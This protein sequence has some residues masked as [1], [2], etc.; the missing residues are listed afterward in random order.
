ML[1]DA[2]SEP[3][4]NPSRDIAGLRSQVHLGTKPIVPGSLQV[5]HIC[6]IVLGTI[7]MIARTVRRLGA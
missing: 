1:N 3:L 7:Q 6:G 4:K 5:V 2:V